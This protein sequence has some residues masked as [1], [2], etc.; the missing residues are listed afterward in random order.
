MPEKVKLLYASLITCTIL[1]AGMAFW[2]ITGLV[3]ESIRIENSARDTLIGI[4]S[5][6][7]YELQQVIDVLNQFR[8]GEPTADKQHLINKF[9]ILWS[10][11]ETNT[12]GLAG[13]AYLMLPGAKP[14]MLKLEK[15]LTDTEESVNSLTVSTPK[16]AEQLV[17]QFKAM[18]PILH[19]VTME[20]SRYTSATTSRLHD[21]LQQVGFWAKLFLPGMLIT[22]FLTGLIFWYEK[23]RL[24]QL[25]SDLE[26]TILIRTKDLQETNITLQEEIEERKQVEA[27]LIQAQK[28]EIVGQLTG[29]IAHDFNNFLAIIQGNAE[30]L[31]EAAKGQFSD[32]VDPI[33]KATQKGSELTQRLLAFSR[34]QPLTP[35]SFDLSDLVD[36]MYVLLRR[37]VGE[38]INIYI[39]SEEGLWNAIADPGQV[40]NALLNLA[41]NSRHAMPEGG[42]INIISF[43]FTAYDIFNREDEELAPGD[44]VV[45]TVS[46]TGT[47]ISEEAKEHVFEPFFTTKK[48]GEGTG[49]G[50]SMIYGFAKQS[51][52]HISLYSEV[53]HGTT[54]KLYLPRS[55]DEETTDFVERIPSA[56]EKGKGEN[57]LVVEDDPDVR[58]L[59]KQLL[60]S[61]NYTVVTAE[62][63][64]TARTY[65][66]QGQMVD[67]ILCDV[68]LPGEFSGPEFVETLC[69][70][71]PSLKVIFMSGYPAGA[72]NEQKL[73]GKEHIFLSKPFERHKLAQA[74][75][76]ALD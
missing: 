55:Q 14:A 36:N 24:D 60:S 47:G 39:K 1:M 52:G 4:T 30:L 46:D 6:T 28:M 54:I 65:L 43:N 62:D 76:N 16:T 49:L 34:Q 67:A 8:M 23:R 31:D 20:A 26:S 69:K 63:T 11:R 51:G 40:E 45:L 35:K 38:T 25:S 27:K 73:L 66:E 19:S 41:V 2:M 58:R 12:S 48:T 50:L 72:A 74:L 3:Q 37:T 59:V 53:G 7:D 33:L 18:A 71:Y 15:L 17:A 70:T 64:D 21:H 22:G 5:Q 42:E 61:M 68:V 32:N 57:I 44:Y 9:D 75:R 10:R 29:G 56:F 13:R